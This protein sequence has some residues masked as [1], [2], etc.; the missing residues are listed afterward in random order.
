M[1]SNFLTFLITNNKET[2]KSEKFPALFKNR[3]TKNL[4]GFIKNKLRSNTNR[5][6]SFG[7]SKKTTRTP[8]PLKINFRNNNKIRLYSTSVKNYYGNLRLERLAKNK[9]LMMLSK[10]KKQAQVSFVDD[11]WNTLY[12]G[13]EA[14]IKQI[15]K[16][17]NFPFTR[18]RNKTSFTTSGNFDESVRSITENR[19]L[20]YKSLILQGIQVHTIKK[21]RNIFLSIPMQKVIKS[22]ESPEGGQ[23]E[24]INIKLGHLI[25]LKDSNRF[26]D[27]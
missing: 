11:N 27:Y 25:N 23:R 1:D 3:Y 9:P 17:S 16:R 6:S 12:I 19:K 5:A 14:L 20:S 15:K 26:P 18:I 2:H 22:M 24:R 13:K 4:L 7:S 21:Q 10:N 8:K